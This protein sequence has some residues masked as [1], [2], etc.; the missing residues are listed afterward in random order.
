MLFPSALLFFQQFDLLGY[1][2]PQPV[3]QGILFVL[4]HH[5]PN[6]VY[7]ARIDG[8]FGVMLG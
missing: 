7:P 4:P 3:P 6:V 8:K 2:L 1:A 5:V